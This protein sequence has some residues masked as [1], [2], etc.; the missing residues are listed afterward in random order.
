MQTVSI[1]QSVDMIPDGASVLVGDAAPGAVDWLVQD[2][3]MQLAMKLQ[4][5]GAESFSR[6]A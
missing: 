2:L 5:F 1:K 3:V 4:L 6:F